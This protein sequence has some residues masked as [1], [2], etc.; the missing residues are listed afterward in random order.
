[1]NLGNYRTMKR[2]LIQDNDFW[3]RVLTGDNNSI[4]LRQGVDFRTQSAGV[5][6]PLSQASGP[7]SNTERRRPR[8]L[9]N[10]LDRIQLEAI[11]KKW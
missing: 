4:G 3:V 6:N 1:M 9:F 5:D 10:I 11:F 2:W 8:W 7:R